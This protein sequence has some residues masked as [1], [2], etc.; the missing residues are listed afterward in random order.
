[1]GAAKLLRDW[2]SALRALQP[3]TDLPASTWADRYR[4]LDQVHHADPGPWETDRVPY[5]REVM[6]AYSS[7]PWVLYLTVM[8]STQIGKTESALNCLLWQI[9]SDP[10]PVLWVMPTEQVVNYWTERRF[11]PAVEHCRPVAAK[12][13]TRIR[14]WK[15]GELGFGDMIVYTGWANSPVM[16]ASKSIGRVF[17]DEV[18]IFPP[19]SG[20][21]GTPISL[22]DERLRWFRRRGDSKRWL[23]ST[24][25]LAEGYIH[26]EYQAGTQE[27][28]HVP[29]P[30]CGYY[31]PLEFSRSSVV[32]PDGE[33]DP[34]R[35]RRERLAAYV[36]C[37]CH[38]QIADEEGLK[39][40][41]LLA[42]VW[43]PKGAH[44]RANGKVVGADPKPEHRSFQ[45]SAMLSP[46]LSWSDVA[47]KF[48]ESKDDQAKLMTF[49]NDWL[50]LPWV[51]KST[52]TSIELVRSRQARHERSTVP[53]AALCLTAGV[54][55]QLDLLYYA[56]RAW[57]VGERS[58]LVEADRVEHWEQLEQALLFRGFPV[59]DDAGDQVVDE[60]GEPKELRLRAGLI[61]SRYRR[62]EVLDL[63]SRYQDILRPIQGSP[64]QPIAIKPRKMDPRY[65][66]RSGVLWTVDV[67]YMKNKLARLMHCER[68]ERGSWELHRDVAEELLVQLTSEHRVLARVKGR[69]ETRE[70][71]RKR[72]GGGANHWWD[73]EVY[74]CAAAE[75]LLLW[76]LRDENEEQARAM[77]AAPVPR[78][79]TAAEVQR[80]RGKR[81][82]RRRRD[83][84]FI[85]RKGRR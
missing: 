12:R 26:V 52:E 4:V 75:M 16:L 10:V 15:A 45:L 42:G 61:D 64:H 50:G 46:A 23:S 58:W 71:W 48:L 7:Q 5:M 62:D 66:G 21:Q 43:C 29:C 9:A 69:V 28:Y 18:E 13:S 25:R 6:D 33:R 44:V 65:H 54:D 3:P 80:R 68:G 14:D 20:K 27:R 19:F 67:H 32:W 17:M 83:G 2:P 41:M 1:M 31:Q 84:S 53:E 70:E 37:E 73:C 85:R 38:K 35:I 49:Y 30:F 24:P 55:V 57:G 82:V 39:A 8:A 63:C 72:P 40:R 34:V 59:V 56:I 76:Q 22:A 74:N 47:A 51:E 79:P 60:L 78:K 81:F 36:C 77:F 11:K